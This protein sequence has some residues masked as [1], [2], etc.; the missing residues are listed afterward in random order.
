MQEN[1][2]CEFE[3]GAATK[4]IVDYT[5][6]VSG[7]ESPFDDLDQSAIDA[8]EEALDLLLDLHDQNAWE[9]EE[10]PLLLNQDG[11]CAVEEADD[12]IKAGVST[13]VYLFRLFN[14]AG[15]TAKP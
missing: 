12:L 1:F 13:P 15:L 3:D 9:E 14:D 7:E 2:Y 8:S 11:L 10:Q 6:H 4:L 5:D